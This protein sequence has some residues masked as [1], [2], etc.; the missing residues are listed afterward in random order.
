VCNSLVVSDPVD[1][2][3]ER[4]RAVVDVA[5]EDYGDPRRLVSVF[6]LSPMVSTNRVYR[7][8]LDDE[9][10]AI[11]KVSNYGSFFLFAEDHDRLHRCHELLH[12]GRYEHF[13]ADSLTTGSRPYIWYDGSIWAVLYHEVPVRDRLPRVLTQVQID[14]LAEEVATFHR[15]CSDIAPLVPPTSKTIKSDAIHLLDLVS[16]RHAAARFGLDQSRLDV[17][18][19][20]T[21]RFL[22]AVLES[23]Y[24]YWQRIPVLIDWNLGNFSVE[25]DAAGRFS[26]FSRWDYDWFRIESRLLDFYFLSRVSSRT[27]D[28]TRFTYSAHTLL[29]PRFRRFLEVYHRWFPLSADEVLFLKETYRFFL[30]NY[31]V[32][33]GEHF[34]RY[35]IWQH[36]LHDVVDVHLPA[37]DELDLTPLTTLIS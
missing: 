22:V 15:T 4:L 30:L 27:G 10:T 6:E 35:D 14:N 19:R 12:G 20:H 7:L 36:L 33:E 31:V 1:A 16:E 32:R 18:R 24:D 29:E 11:A 8:T 34:F 13:L 21:H 37:L 23:N 25:F 3:E 2:T 9:S 5:W 17:V 28:K 26:L